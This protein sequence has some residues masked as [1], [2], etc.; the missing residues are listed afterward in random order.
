VIDI[1][2]I[3]GH[4]NETRQN[5]YF[6]ARPQRS[7]VQWPNGKHNTFPSDA[8]DI[9]PWVNGSIPWDDSRY[10]YTLA[11]VVMAAAAVEGVE[12]RAGYDWDGDTDVTDQ[13]FHDLGHFE[14][15]R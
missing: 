3:D 5:E 2:I 4:R 11:G 9:A 8:A 10:W 12:L 1:A 14:R 7:K 13:S 6:N 15:K